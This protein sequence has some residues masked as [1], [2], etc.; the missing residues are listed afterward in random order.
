[1]PNEKRFDYIYEYPCRVPGCRVVW[2]HCWKP[3]YVRKECRSTETVSQRRANKE[4]Y[5][6]MIE[7]ENQDQPT[8]V[9]ESSLM[10]NI[11]TVE[12]RNIPYSQR[13]LEDQLLFMVSNCE[14][15]DEGGDEVLAA[16]KRRQDQMDYDDNDPARKRFTMITVPRRSRCRRP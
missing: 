5:K 8:V 9:N 12:D 3:G 13:P 1:M 2:H 6:S 4:V 14:V 10:E 16:E 7:K 11:L 15:T